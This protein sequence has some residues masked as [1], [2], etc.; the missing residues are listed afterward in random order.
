MLTKRMHRENV[1]E[2][3]YRMTNKSWSYGEVVEWE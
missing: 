2:W 3:E 1:V